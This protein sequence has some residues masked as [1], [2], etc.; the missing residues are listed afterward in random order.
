MKEPVLSL[1]AVLVKSEML[2]DPGLAF[3]KLNKILWQWWGG[4]IGSE[5][6]IHIAI[7]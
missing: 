4:G 5:V 6:N 2:S 1:K 7:A 3:T